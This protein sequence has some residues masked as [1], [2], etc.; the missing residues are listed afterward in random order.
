LA[1]DALASLPPRP[2]ADD[3]TLPRVAIIAPYRSQVNL[4][5][6]KLREAQL[7]HLV[8]VGTI[9]TVQSLEFPVV[10]FDTVEAPP[11][12][13][14]TFTVDRLFDEHQMATV[15]TRLLTV[16]WTRARYKL[17]VIA[18]RTHLVR[19]HA[20]LSRRERP[21]NRQHLLIALVD[22]AYEQGHRS[23]TEMRP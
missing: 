14:W 23:A 6:K 16:A 7:A 19:H 8:H 5:Q 10:I 12:H 3:P 4:I 20:L 11:L 22:W 9:H 18:H 15:A 21:E 2:P 13:P 1:R 17:I